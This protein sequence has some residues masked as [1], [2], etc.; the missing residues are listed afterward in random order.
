MLE[1]A[2]SQGTADAIPPGLQQDGRMLL[3]KLEE[4]L[5]A[6]FEAR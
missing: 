6:D 5:V 4:L 3:A 2:R 1:A